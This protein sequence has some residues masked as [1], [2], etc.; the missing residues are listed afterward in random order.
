MLLKLV[1]D[2]TKFKFTKYRYFAI[3]LSTLLNIAALTAVFTVGLNFGVDF[4]GGV[5]VEVAS[6]RPIDLG[7]VRT[8]MNELGLGATTVQAITETG[9]GKN[10]VVVSVERSESAEQKASDGSPADSGGVVVERLKKL[11]GADIEVRR[12]DVVGPTVSGELIQ[13]GVIAV[14]IMCLVIIGYIWSRYEWQFGVGAIVATIHDTLLTLGMLV[15]FRVPFDIA[16]IAAVLTV[17]GYSVND[18]VVV[19]DRMREN[20]RKFKK[21]PFDELID[22]SLNETLS[23]T[24]ATSL[25]VIISLVPLFLFGGDVLRGF[26]AAILFG[27]FV[28]TYSSIYIAAPFLMVTGVKREW[29]K[30]A[31]TPA[32]P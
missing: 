25:T 15:L 26:S 11:L 20:L 13:K 23:R 8:A 18:T 30:G 4:R 3:A 2:H 1:P 22:L 6:A 5:T 28:G 19:F 31:P 27:I 14:V 17:V 32:T 24:V 21:M 16:M 12:V 29:L 7:G 9:T 10:G